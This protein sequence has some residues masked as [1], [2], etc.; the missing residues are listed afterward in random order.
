ML[1]CDYVIYHQPRKKFN[2]RLVLNERKKS[3][4]CHF[5]IF[6]NFISNTNF[7]FD[8]S[9]GLVCRGLIESIPD[10]NIE[11]FIALSTPQGGQFGGKSK[12]LYNF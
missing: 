9:G 6:L 11:S 8:L 12:I 1:H 7:K 4:N 10:H 2:V 3:Q 5:S